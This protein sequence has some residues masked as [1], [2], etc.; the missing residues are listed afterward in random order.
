MISYLFRSDVC[1]LLGN[2]TTSRGSAT[3]EQA[4]DLKKVTRT[5]HGKVHSML[6]GVILIFAFI[7]A[8]AFVIALPLLAAFPK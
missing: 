6:H 8:V 1:S 2:L 7:V 3:G 5:H 4:P